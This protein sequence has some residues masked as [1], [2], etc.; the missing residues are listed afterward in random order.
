[1]KLLLASCTVLVATVSASAPLRTSPLSKYFGPRATENK[2]NK[3]PTLK[4]MPPAVL[5]T[6]NMGSLY[7]PTSNDF[8]ADGGA[9]L[10]GSGW[11]INGGGGVHGKTAFN[12]LGGYIE[13]DMDVTGAHNNVNN[14]LYTSSP[15]PGLFPNYCDI[16]ANDSPQCMEMDIIENNGGCMAQSTWHTWPN[17]DGDCDESGCWAQIGIGGKGRFHVKADF[18]SDGWMSVNID[19]Q[20]FAYTHPVPSNNAKAY[21]AQVMKSTGA[22]IQSSQWQGWVPGDCGG[23]DLGSSSFTVSNLRV[24]G[25]VVQGNQPATC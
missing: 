9:Q 21:V 15:W 6:T 16:Q 13:F 5:N 12:L 19:G 10:H 3:Q 1:M 22:Q 25:S 7:C 23:G 8:W 11:T 24:Q 17:H 4:M 14:N 20:Q 18:S 2:M